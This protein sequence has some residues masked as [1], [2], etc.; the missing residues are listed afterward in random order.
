LDIAGPQGAA[1]SWMR[2]EQGI[3]APITQALTGAG[4]ATAHRE[5]TRAADGRLLETL[6]VR[7]TDAG[8]RAL[9]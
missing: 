2:I 3:D 4:Y 1:E 5:R 6:V 7:L 8:R 9:R